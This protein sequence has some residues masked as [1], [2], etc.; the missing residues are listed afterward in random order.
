MHN[1]HRFN[2]ILSLARH[3]EVSFRSTPSELIV[4]NKNFLRLCI[5][6]FIGLGA[7][8]SA[9][10]YQV[11]QTLPLGG[12]G[13]WDYLSVDPSAHLLYLSRASH[14]AIVDTASGKIVGDIADT[15]GVHGIAIAADLGRGY[16]SAGK[17][18]QVKVFD[19]STRQTLAAIA[20]GSKPDAIVYEPITHQ[21]FAFNGHS[22]DASVID[23]T[24][25]K[26]VQTIALGGGP[27][28]ARTDGAGMIFVNI[29]DKNELVALNAA[30][31]RQ[32]AR[33]PLPGCDGPTGLALDTA[34]HRSFSVCANAKMTILDTQT[35]KAIATLPIGNGVDGADFDP[36]SRNAFSANGEGTLTVVHE[37]DPDHFTVI[38]T[39]RTSQG[40]R[41]VAFD[42]SSHALFLPSAKFGA[43]SPTPL[44]AHPKPPILPDSFFLLTVTPVT[45]IK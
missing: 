30:T 32:T 44:D 15:P 29:E 35:G 16:I 23:T 28:F 33:W 42:S 17:S 24:T 36:D 38:Q 41:T 4:P 45:G 21:V 26:V 1:S 2:A 3:N 18:N 22:N 31:R 11:A 20:V 40:A 12:D 27:E 7:M 14:V 34:H 25:N 13:S 39:L 37:I 10:P 6:S 8:A 19:L 9:A 5:A 43:V